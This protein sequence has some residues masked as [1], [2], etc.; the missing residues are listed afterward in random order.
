M[1]TVCLKLYTY[2]CVL[3][4]VLHAFNRLSI[5][6]GVKYFHLTA[7]LSLICYFFIPK[8]KDRIY[9]DVVLLIV[10]SLI[11]S[12]LSPVENSFLGGVTLAIVIFSM[13]GVREV[14]DKKIIHYLNMGSAVIVIALLMHYFS[15]DIFRY[16]G[17]YEDPNYM[18]TTLLVLLYFILLEF[19]Q[20][21]SLFWKILLVVE[22]FFILFLVAVSLS[23]TGL[24][25]AFII[26]T[27]SFFSFIKRYKIY[28]F[29]FVIASAIALNTWQPEFVEKAVA[30]LMDRQNSTNDNF[31]SARSHRFDLSVV[32]L[33]YLFSN[34]EY[35]I[36]GIGVGGTHN[37]KYFS[38]FDMKAGTNR[39]HNTFTSSLTE[40]GL[41][42]FYCYVS[43]IILS[44]L[45]VFRKSKIVIY[46]Y[47]T[48]GVMISMV[49]FSL[50]IWQMNYLPFWFFFFF[51]TNKYL[52]Q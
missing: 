41:V 29:F 48:L 44:F 39:D 40:Q 2:L 42:G 8:T 26:L 46:K 1:S 5:V 11:S 37:K 35:W 50:S 7:L 21:K 24:F 15:E 12:L 30:G 10:I 38:G 16:Q 17:Y 19:M 34:P 27:I 43:I 4:L 23:R 14:K 52:I 31:D 51:A 22:I 49:V 13:L 47:I 32:G 36:Q 28:T 20:L 18:C 3:S 33:S 6:E 25:A 9:R 45:F